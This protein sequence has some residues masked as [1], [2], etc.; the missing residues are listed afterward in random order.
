MSALTWPGAV[1]MRTANGCIGEAY[2][3]QGNKVLLA[4]AATHI[5][6]ILL[7][8]SYENVLDSVTS[9]ILP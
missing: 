3:P 1:T 8:Q 6:L 9:C 4:V 7:Q 2:L 5:Y